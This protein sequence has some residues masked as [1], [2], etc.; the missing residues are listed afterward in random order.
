MYHCQSARQR[1]KKES[2]I[3]FVVHNSGMEIQLQITCR[4]VALQKA[5]T[6]VELLQSRCRRINF[7]VT[8]RGFFDE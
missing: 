6:S 3:F 8:F 1:G 2:M 5:I 7:E 4:G